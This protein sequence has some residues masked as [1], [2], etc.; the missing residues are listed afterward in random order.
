[1]RKIA[2]KISV[3]GCG[4]WPTTIAKL[5]AENGHEV[6]IWCHRQGVADEINTQHAHTK[7]LPD[8]ILPK[9]LTATLDMAHALHQSD[10][11]IIGLASSYYSHIP[12]IL[13][14]AGKSPVLSL[15]KGL[16]PDPDFL[17][18]TYLTKGFGAQRIAVLSGPNLAKEIAHKKPSAT[19]I[20]SKNKK[21]ATY[22]QHT[23]SNAYFRA[24]TSR[25]IVGVELGGVLKNT[26]A[27]AV[28]V[29]DGLGLGSNAKAALI[30]RGLNEMIRF[31]KSF[32]A[33][34][35]T[36]VGLSG[37][38]DLIATC[39]SHQSRN[40]RV[41]MGLARGEKCDDILKNLG[42]HAEGVNT[43]RMVV[44]HARYHDISMPVTEAAYDVLFNN[45]TAKQ[46]FEI[47]MKRE[48]KQE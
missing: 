4:T 33:K 8:V 17:I 35:D 19:V 37:L 7:V 41:G 24:Y 21:I 6:S 26:M 31:S 12:D 43:T 36:L 5:L 28:G 25:D 11:V 14:N 27:I 15:T 48:L 18:S 34:A 38:G 16:L 2:S 22:F 45:V 9:N 40:Y 39:D 10:A 13:K 47:L 23:L 30:T 46:A 1:M 44:E 42:Q 32:G 29:S 3:V 20:A